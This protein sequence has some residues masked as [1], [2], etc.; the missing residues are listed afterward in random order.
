[1]RIAGV[2]LSLVV[3]VISQAGFGSADSV[4]AETGQVE[5]RAGYDNDLK[6][7]STKAA[8]AESLSSTHPED[9]GAPFLN[10]AGE[11]VL[12]VATPRGARLAQQWSRDTGV[13][14][15]TPHI[16][17]SETQGAVLDEGVDL[18]TR[19]TESGVGGDSIFV[20][21]DGSEAK[22]V[23]LVDPSRVASVEDN[24]KH[25]SADAIVAAN[26]AGE[27]EY[28]QQSRQNDSS[29]FYGGAKVWLWLENG[30]ATCTGGFTWKGPSGNPWLL[31]AGHCSQ[32]NANWNPRV[33]FTGDGTTQIGQSSN[34]YTTWDNGTGTVPTPGRGSLDGDLALLNLKNGLNVSSRIWI[35]GANSTSS[36]P[37]SGVGSAAVGQK[38]CFSGAVTGESCAFT[39]TAIGAQVTYPKGTVRPAVQS[40]SFAAHCS[41]NGDSGAPVYLKGSS[42]VT[43]IGILSGGGGGG[44]D[45]YGGALDPC[46]MVFTNIQQAYEAFDGYVP[47]T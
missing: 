9:L 28:H 36:L 19:L 18:A 32:Y 3:G 42:S 12:P 15:A 17:S 43:A 2:S 40:I 35:G 5:V 41:A 47:L 11:V 16:G 25:I 46:S 45:N 31:T 30:S 4:S 14:A 39:V 22:P 38:L 29:P 27:G 8:T 21:V 24:L 13:P 20:T 44:S 34:Q 37:V 7:A 10:E 6:D 26:P 23:L 1:M 33:V